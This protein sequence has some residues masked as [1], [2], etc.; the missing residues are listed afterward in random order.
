ML[1]AHLL[2][3]VPYNTLSLEPVWVQFESQRTVNWNYFSSKVVALHLFKGFFFL[4][5]SHKHSF[6]VL[7]WIS[8]ALRRNFEG[9]YL[10]NDNKL[11]ELLNFLRAF[12]WFFK[13]FNSF[14][15]LFL[16]LFLL[17]LS[18][19]PY[20]YTFRRLLSF[21]F[22]SFL[23]Y[24]LRFLFCTPFFLFNFSHVLKNFFLVAC[25]NVPLPSLRSDFFSTLWTDF[26]LVLFQFTSP[27]CLE[28]CL[29]LCSC[30]WR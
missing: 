9:Y 12:F 6:F 27:Y 29:V 23:L 16:Q 11:F 7:T 10:V 15:N 26:V 30:S 20:Y 22:D 25:L 13:H 3:A 28:V 14:F 19:L 8:N 4:C 24:P 18:P 1:I 2:K 5:L 21:D 17:F